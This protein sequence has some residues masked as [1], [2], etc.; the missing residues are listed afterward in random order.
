[1]AALAALIIGMIP[2]AGLDWVGALYVLAALVLTTVRPPW[3]LLVFAV[4]LMVPV[5][6]ALVT[7]H[8]QWA[9]YFT[10]GVLIAAVPL[11]VVV[12]LI[13]A[14]QQLQAA[15]SALAQ[16]AVI[17]ERLRIDVSCARRWAQRLRR[18]PCRETALARSPPA[19]HPRPPSNCVP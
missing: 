14:A 19:T 11:A 3:S 1:M 7:G 6:V 17:R 13:R 2:V 9:S 18:S 12:W 15:R 4:L 10:L 16:Q 8:P 5:P